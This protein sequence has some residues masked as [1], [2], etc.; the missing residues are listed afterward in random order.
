MYLRSALN[1]LRPR[2]THIL[3]ISLDALRAPYGRRDV[4]ALARRTRN[5]PGQ[6]LLRRDR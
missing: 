3:R 6:A 5:R 2:L 4:P 1:W